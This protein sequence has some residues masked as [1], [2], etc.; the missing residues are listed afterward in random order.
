[1]HV[2]SDTFFHSCTYGSMRRK[3]AEEDP[4]PE[5]EDVVKNL[6]SALVTMIKEG[7]V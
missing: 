5:S 7:T 1:M 6:C 3:G 2:A 4:F